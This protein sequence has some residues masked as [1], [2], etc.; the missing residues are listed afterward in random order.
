MLPDSIW[1]ANILEETTS[2]LFL[3]NPSAAS[4]KDFLDL[5]SQISIP[6]IANLKARKGPF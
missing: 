4:N 2:Y 1:N 6:V 5:Q 3:E